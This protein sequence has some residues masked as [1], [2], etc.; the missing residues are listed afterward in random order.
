M[1][2][3]YGVGSVAAAP[4]SYSSSVKD[5]N[6][7]TITKHRL[8]L[9]FVISARPCTDVAASPSY[10]KTPPCNQPV[11]MVSPIEGR[12]AAD[13]SGV[14]PGTCNY[15]LPL[16]WSPSGFRLPSGQSI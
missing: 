10:P 11:A 12:P 13:C 3:G 1:C 15:M 6:T 2:S 8:R 16:I 14:L 7:K 4:N 5:T 9:D